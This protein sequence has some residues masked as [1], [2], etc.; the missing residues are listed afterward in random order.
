MA[1]DDGNRP[2]QRETYR[3]DDGSGGSFLRC[4]GFMAMNGLDA[5]RTSV[6]SNLLSQLSLSREFLGHIQLHN[7]QQLKMITVD[8]GC[9]SV[10]LVSLHVP[11]HPIKKTPSVDRS[12]LL[13]FSLSSS[14][15][16]M[17]F[18]FLTFDPQQ[19]KQSK[20]RQKDNI[21]RA[22]SL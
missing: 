13:A 20:Q 8:N 11:Y 17:D 21:L 2:P 22:R 15:A 4:L 5:Q 3:E 9:L 18:T 6:L 14:F 16:P 7:L 12:T 19:Q 1:S 10:Q